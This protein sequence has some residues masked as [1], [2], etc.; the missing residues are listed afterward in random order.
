MGKNMMK[1]GW[2][3]DLQDYREFQSTD[4]E[5]EAKIYIKELAYK[6]IGE[7]LKKYNKETGGILIG[8]YSTS[9]RNV[10]INEFG[11]APEDSQSGFS[12]FIRGVKGLRN[13]LKTK[14]NLNNEYYLGEWH[15]HPANV[16]E[17]SATDIFQMKIIS[18]DERF[19][20]KEPILIIFS[21]E[22]EDIYNT[23]IRLLLKSYFYDF[24]EIADEHDNKS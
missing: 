4:K 10:Y 13:Y 8:Y 5:C 12:Y 11:D 23:T 14:W 1:M 15:F 19:N 17:P 9:L 2:R 3:R 24:I 6:R 16:K 22:R 20:C 21:K 18:V 7:K